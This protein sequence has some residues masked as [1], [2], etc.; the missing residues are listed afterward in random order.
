MR[1]SLAGGKFNALA[2]DKS[3]LSTQ[4]GYAGRATHRLPISWDE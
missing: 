3:K 4:S 2:P 1:F